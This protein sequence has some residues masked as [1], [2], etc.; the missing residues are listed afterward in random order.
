MALSLR[1]QVSFDDH[2]ALSLLQQVSFD[3]HMA[4]SLRQQVSFECHMPL[5]QGSCGTHTL[6]AAA[7]LTNSAKAS[8]RS[9]G[10]AIVLL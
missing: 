10:V 9:S 3:D 1:Q 7:V 2:M 4:L 6:A 8:R 5:S